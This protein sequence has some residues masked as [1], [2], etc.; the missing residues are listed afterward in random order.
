MIDW[1]V[2]TL[3]PRWTILG[4][5]LAVGTI[6]TAVELFKLYRAPWLDA[7]RLTFPGALLLGRV[8][9]IR[10]L[11]FYALAILAGALADRAIRSGQ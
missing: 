1:I 10:D 7:F 6:A 9:A 4:N 3:R 5:A 8:F 2:S 11:F